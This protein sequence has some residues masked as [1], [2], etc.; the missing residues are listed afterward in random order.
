MRIY[1]A[2]AMF[3]R[4]DAEYNL[5][6]AAKLR[7][8][9]FAVYC[10][11]E[12]EPINDKTRT[13]VTG[14]LIYQVDIG[15]LEAS[16]VVLLQV[17][18]DSGS[19]WEAGYMDALTRYHPTGA[20]YGVMGLATDIRLQSIPTPAQSGVDNQAGYLNQLIV[21]G[22]Q[23]SLGIFVHEDQAIAAL[24]ALRTEVGEEP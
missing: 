15:E 3:T 12:S 4:A 16:N 6:L 23:E 1:M 17:S 2:G 7:A 11:N 9:D 8:A 22:L 13:D 14:R 21:G 5:R 18:E 20:Y 19:N 10:P 24:I